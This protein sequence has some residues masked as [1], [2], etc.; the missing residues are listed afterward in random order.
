MEVFDSPS[1]YYP[2]DAMWCRLFPKIRD[3][4]GQ[5][6]SCRPGSVRL[7]KVPPAYRLAIEPG[8]IRKSDSGWNLTLSD[9]Q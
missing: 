1:H 7:A 9:Q 4:P 2:S 3:G 8:T 5:Q 6:H